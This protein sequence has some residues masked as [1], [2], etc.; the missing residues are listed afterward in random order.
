[1]VKGHPDA[2]CEGY[3]TEDQYH[4]VCKD[5]FEDFKKQ[6]QWNVAEDENKA[7]GNAS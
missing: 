5:C 6:F 3:C 7:L 2:L 1:M 4:W